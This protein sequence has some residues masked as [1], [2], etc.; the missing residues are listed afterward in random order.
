MTTF[1]AVPARTED[2]RSPTAAVTSAYATYSPDSE[3]PLRGYAV[4]AGLYGAGLG[5]FVLYTR[6]QGRRLPDKLPP[7]DVL[8]LGAATYKAARLIS[9]DKITSVVRAPF[10]RRKEATSASEVADEPRGHGLRLAVGELL[11]CPFCLS[12]WVAGG[13][14]CG[15]LTAPRITRTIAGGLTA[16]TIADWLQYAWSATQQQAE[17]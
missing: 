6:A 15:Y 11:A 14:T 17:D 10:T 9:K 2:T 3:V 13:L 7:W 16:M 5:L 1:E 12:A 8:L 4:L